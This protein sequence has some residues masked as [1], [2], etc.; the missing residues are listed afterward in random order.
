MLPTTTA[1]AEISN[2]PEVTPA[3]ALTLAYVPFVRTLAGR[4]YGSL[5]PGSCLELGDLV[6]AGIVGLVNA[7]QSYQQDSGVPFPLHAKHRIRGEIIDT[8]RKL[9]GAPRPLRRFERTMKS[10]HRELTAKLQRQPTEEEVTHELGR[11]HGLAPGDVREKS[12]ELAA[13][14]SA[15]RSDGEPG[16]VPARA[17]CLPDSICARKEGRELLGQAVNRLAGRQKELIRLYYSGD[18]TMKEIGEILQVNES[19]ISQM[20]KGALETMARNLRALGIRKR[21]DI[22][23]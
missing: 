8:L 4:V 6:Q 10:V 5:P 16:E 17:E 21:A 18:Y 15:A 1:A 13:L 22:E 2:T 9:D 11:E 23:A 3:E 19:R 20:H 14:R 12:S 7:A